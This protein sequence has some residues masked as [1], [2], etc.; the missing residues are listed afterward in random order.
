MGVWDDLGNDCRFAIP[1]LALYLIFASALARERTN[2]VRGIAV[3]M[4]VLAVFLALLIGLYLTSM[5]LALMAVSAN[6]SIH[7]G[8]K[9]AIVKSLTLSLGYETLFI[10]GAIKGLRRRSSAFERVAS[11]NGRLA[12]RLRHVS[13]QGPGEPLLT[14]SLELS[15]CAAFAHEQS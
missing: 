12:L 7:L 3:A 13:M 8:M 6:P 1:T 15:T 4:I 5:P 14:Q 11:G 10:V 9:K 2:F